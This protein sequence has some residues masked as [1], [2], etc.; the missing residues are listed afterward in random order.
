[1]RVEGENERSHW[2]SS[3]SRRTRT[4]AQ[5]SCRTRNRV[6]TVAQ[7]FV[8]R[9][10]RRHPWSGRCC[11]RSASHQP[12]M[13]GI[14][15][16]RMAPITDLPAALLTGLAA[17]IAAL[18][19]AIP[20]ILGA[21][22][23]LVL[24]WIITGALAGLVRRGLR[25]IKVDAMAERVGVTGFLRR[26]QIKTDTSG[27]VAGV[28]KWYLR[29]IVILMA[30]DTVHLTTVSTIVNQVLAFI[31]SL[32][33]AVLILGAFSWLASRARALVTGA[34]E[35][36]MPNASTIGF[37]AYAATLGFGVIAAATQIGVA[38]A[39]IDILFTG[40]V[41]GLALAFGLAFGLG[42]REE[43]AQI[44]R[45]MRSSVAAMPARPAAPAPSQA[46]HFLN[47]RPVERTEEPGRILRRA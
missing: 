39:I 33:V 41:A 31:P 23:V 46:E 10:N 14:G 8:F 18:L 6:T 29:L 37:L 22:I 26:A 21:L 27:L 36:S 47:G 25:A 34:L 20:V 9:P 44:W 16:I 11:A 43:A 40:I 19:S 35:P 1:M 4:T 3:H 17:G 13:S 30:A 2:C 15:G 5:R 38:T 42:G 28:V 45:N 7:S 12:G 32:I 24:G